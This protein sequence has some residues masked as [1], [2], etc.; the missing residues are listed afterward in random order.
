[1]RNFFALAFILLLTAKFSAQVGINTN[2]NAPD[3]SSMLDI[4]SEDKGILIPR[5]NSE[6]RDNIGLP[7]EGLLIYNT[8]TRCFE[9]FVN[10]VWSKISCPS[11]CSNT[12]GAITGNASMCQGGSSSYSVVMDNAASC[13]WSYIGNGA[14]IQNNGPFSVTVIFSEFATSGMLVAMG[15]TS[16]SQGS[17]V[18]SAHFPIV[19]S[20]LPQAAGFISGDDQVCAGTGG[21]TYSVEP[22]A[23]AEGY[24][25]QLP[26][27]ATIVSGEGTASITV[28]FS[29]QSGQITVTPVNA[30]GN[31]Q[32]SS[33]FITVENGVPSTPGS[34]NGSFLANIN[35]AGTYSI[36]PFIRQSGVY[37]GN[38]SIQRVLI[39]SGRCFSIGELSGNGRHI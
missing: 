3:P 28:N 39:G 31:G 15:T 2:G 32:S 24:N 30:R 27:G 38:Y 21:L 5:L 4:T 10:G 16:C 6:Q 35:S 23:G 18:F 20:D 14:T 36:S 9:S 33:S 22:V 34:I 7:A 11:P 8:V 13:M 26:P 12:S 19:I 25:W 29:N 37:L 1:M 17:G